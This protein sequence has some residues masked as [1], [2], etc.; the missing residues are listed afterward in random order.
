MSS[1]SNNPA[2]DHNSPA[3]SEVASSSPETVAPAG[4]SDAPATE[5]LADKVSTAATASPTV[6]EDPPVPVVAPVRKVAIGSQ[7]DTAD[8][9]L[10]PSQPRAV[11]NAV[12]NPINLTGEPEPEPVAIPD[13]KS[14]TGFSDD[15]DAE[16]DAV[17][18]DISMD[19][20]VATTEASTEE[21]EPGTRVKAAVTKIHEDNV[22]VRLSGQ[23][24]GIATL[25]HFKE[26]PNEGDLVE[27]IVR[28]LNKEDGLYELA[29][30]GA[31]I[32]V[33]DWDDIT[34][35]AVID[36][37]VTGSNTGGLE[38]AI[39][40]IRGFIPA[41]QIDR[42]RVEDFSAYINQKLTCVVVEVNPEKRKLVLSRRAILDRE[43]EEKRKE[44]LKEL[45][46][47]QL[48]DGVVTKLMDFG[49]FVDLGGVEGLIHVSKVSWS[50][51]KHPS[52]VLTVG[53]NVR[54]KIEKIDENANRISLSH[55]DTLEHPWKGIDTQFAVNDIVKGTVTKIADFGA[56]VKIA[57]GIEGLVHISELAYQR[58]AKV[59]NV[60]KEGQELEV[61]IQSIDPQ[62]QKI[63][64]SHKACLAPPAPKQSAGKKEA[65]EAVEEPARD[66]AVP[67]SGE[68]LKGGTD[69]KSGGEGVGLNW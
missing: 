56:F 24:E 46:A 43:N 38:V 10:Q 48:R 26:A 23:S 5:V 18:G 40:S 55:R 44:L 54:V 53:E 66:L 11:Q 3:P 34:E 16:I 49:A 19:D 64:L 2:N 17:L 41:S 39:N 57:P 27:I 15:V 13:I 33:A 31:S 51:V 37:L 52:E 60:V 25:H 30:P 36:A 8:K 14:D 68:P 22:F 59:S 65:V 20:V 62:S 9:A 21:I 58:V 7:R 35:G 69:R 4:S 61:K 12:A 67:A 47:G 32:G 42:F 28:G 29:V 1:E 45:E 63:S 50:R 6:T